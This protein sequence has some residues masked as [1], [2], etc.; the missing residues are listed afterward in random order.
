M[1]LSE[2]E[3]YQIL[4]QRDERYIGDFIAAIRTTGIYCRPGCPARTPKAENCAFFDSVEAARAAGYRACKRCHPDTPFA[5]PSKRVDE[6]LAVL[7]A[8]PHKVW[9][10]QDIRAAGWD[11]STLRRQF[12]KRFGMSFLAYARRQRLSVA[13]K[14]LQKGERVIN[15]QLDAGYESAS[16]FRAAYKAQFG[17]TPSGEDAQPL[18]I[19][20]IETP[21]GRMISIADEQALFLLEF[22][23]RKNMTGQMARLMRYYTRPII[24][25][26]T[27]ISDQIRQE[28]SLYFE[29]KL[30]N[31]KT[32]LALTGTEFQSRVWQAL[33]D[34]PYGETCS[35]GD[36]AQV[37]GSEKAVRA[38]AS[39]NARNALAIIVPCHRVI[40]KNG[41]MTGYAGG[42]GRKESLL[43]LEGAIKDAQGHLGLESE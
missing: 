25:G 2:S 23:D 27:A 43:R 34:I 28:L 40:G 15:A 41:K 31:F 14:A 3:K 38:V 19:S 8:D 37:I 18:Y 26:T 20:W 29:G 24:P 13:A 22:T 17:T 10:E 30:T 5:A 9:R 6:A 42:L 33:T 35:Y 16:G 7:A 4:T 1:S 12:Q 11:N 39:S 32:P 36:L 21:L